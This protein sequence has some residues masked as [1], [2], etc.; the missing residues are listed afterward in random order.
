MAAPNL[1]RSPSTN[2]RIDTR[3]SFTGIPV[4][5]L[6]RLAGQQLPLKST[7]VIGGDWSVA[8]TPRL[9]GTLNVRR[10]QGDLFATDSA[11]LDATQLAFGI[12]ELTL[13]ARLND[14]A[15]EATARMLATRAGTAN[16]TMSLAAGR[17][18]FEIATDVPFNATITAD[19]PSLK[20]LQPFARH[21]LR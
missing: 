14:D 20:P 13:S 2:G 9:N 18:P 15:V 4:A 3:G 10:E 5:S 12:T 7:L 16:A 6:A 1:P 21:R 8:A 11:T 17:A 19:L